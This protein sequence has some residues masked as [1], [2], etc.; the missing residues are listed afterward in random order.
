[1]NEKRQKQKM[2]IDL[3]NYERKA[4][5]EGGKREGGNCGA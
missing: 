4:E 3:Q 5:V 1:M 2:L